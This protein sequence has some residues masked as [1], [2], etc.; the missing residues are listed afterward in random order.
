VL[1]H[2]SVR[3][4]IESDEQQEGE[5]T[6]DPDFSYQE[7]TLTGLECR[8]QEACNRLQ[9]L[10]YEPSLLLVKV[11]R[12]AKIL[13]RVPNEDAVVRAIAGT[14]MNL[15]SIHHVVGPTC[16]S[17]DAFLR[18]VAVKVTSKEK[19]ARKGL[20]EALVKKR[21]V[22]NRAKAVNT[23]EGIEI[24]KSNLQ[25]LLRWKLTEEEYKL[26]KVADKKKTKEELKALWSEFRD[27]IVLDVDVPDEEENDCMLPAI[28]ET[29]HGKEAKHLTDAALSA[30]QHL[31]PEEI[32]K[33]SST[34]LSLAL[35]KTLK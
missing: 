15:S 2:P 7:A 3:I 10:G 34:T 20:R 8:N 25:L 27:R 28:H 18:A 30:S 1:Q 23:I 12:K 11:K 33:L 4:E 31:H 35:K 24:T 14:G 29:E 17:S 6:Y 22:Q 9:L 16:I 19:D 5:L 26:F 21:D 13:D 32:K